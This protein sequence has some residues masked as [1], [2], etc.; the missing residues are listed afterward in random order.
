MGQQQLFWGKGGDVRPGPVSR[1]S[2]PSVPKMS[3][4]WHPTCAPMGQ[5]GTL[6][7]QGA[8]PRT[9]GALPATAPMYN[10]RRGRQSQ[11]LGASTPW[12]TKSRG[13]CSSASPGASDA[14]QALHGSALPAAKK[15]LL[16]TINVCRLFIDSNIL[17]DWIINS[18]F[19]HSLNQKY[20][21]YLQSLSKNTKSIQR[22]CLS[23]RHKCKRYQKIGDKHCLLQNT[24]Q[25]LTCAVQLLLEY[26]YICAVLPICS[27]I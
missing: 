19:K 26:H 21:K 10:L 24:L 16:E 8:P 9:R 13:G 23:K 17:I 3:P 15:D 2:H 12:R 18:T 22:H 7:L 4:L 20:N 14:P 6:A 27:H 1:T 5:E 25:S 11:N